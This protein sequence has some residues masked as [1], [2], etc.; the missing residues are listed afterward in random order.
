MSCIAGEHGGASMERKAFATQITRDDIKYSGFNPLSHGKWVIIA[1]FAESRESAE[2]LVE[3][4][5]RKAVPV[6]K[7]TGIRN[8]KSG[9]T[10]FFGFSTVSC[11]AC[12]HDT[13]IATMAIGDGSAIHWCPCDCVFDENGQKR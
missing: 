4:L 13:D 5:N 11:P 3:K 2:R 7:L 12:G 6:R 1:D 9:T 8:R 10:M